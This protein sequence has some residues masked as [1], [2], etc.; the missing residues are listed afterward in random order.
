MTGVEI[1]Q[2]VMGILNNQRSA[3]SR[4]ITMI[5]SSKYEVKSDADQILKLLM[6]ST[7]ER[8]HNAIRIGICGA[9]GAGKSSLIES[10]GLHIVKQ[11]RALASVLNSYKKAV[12][13]GA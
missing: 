4:T 5:E 8:R 1:E 6:A 13:N 7:P 10:L 2:R 9:P 11:H 3:L 12:G